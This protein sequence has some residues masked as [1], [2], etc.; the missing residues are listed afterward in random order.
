MQ[1]YKQRYQ[2]GFVSKAIGGETVTFN[3]KDLP[4]S[5][6]TLLLNYRRVAPFA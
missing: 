6:Q 1:G 3:I 2:I 4:A 5:T